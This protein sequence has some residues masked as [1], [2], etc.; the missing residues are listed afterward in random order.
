MDFH[1]QKKLLNHLTI[2]YVEDIDE[3]A[4]YLSSFLTRRFQ[5]VHRAHDGKEAITIFKKHK[6]F[7][8][9]IITDIRMPHIDGIELSRMIKEISSK[10]PVIITTAFSDN[11]YT[12]EAKDIGVDGYITKPIDN[13]EL[14]HLILNVTSKHVS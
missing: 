14:V 7:I 1:K 5:T 10:T 2:L 9:L 8:D 3:V 4:Q 13:D 11:E 6:D 12:D